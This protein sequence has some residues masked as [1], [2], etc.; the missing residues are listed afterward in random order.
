MIQTS[1]YMAHRFSLES[2]YFVYSE[3]PI[4]TQNIIL[5]QQKDKSL[6]EKIQHPILNIKLKLVK[7]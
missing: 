5:H 7:L 1:N 4:E 2:D 3:L 6:V